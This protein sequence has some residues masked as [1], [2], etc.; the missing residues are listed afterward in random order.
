MD[1]GERRR[2]DKGQGRREK[3]N[4]NF[5]IDKGEREEGESDGD[6]WVCLRK[7]S[8]GGKSTEEKERFSVFNFF[9]F[10]L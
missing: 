3:D 5:G 10:L 1:G 8:S 9:G 7:R 4:K 2:R 6:K